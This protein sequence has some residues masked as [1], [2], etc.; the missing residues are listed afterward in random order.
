MKIIKIFTSSIKRFNNKVTFKFC[1][2]IKYSIWLAET[3]YTNKIF[4]Y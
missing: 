1:K 4:V 2:H 3:S